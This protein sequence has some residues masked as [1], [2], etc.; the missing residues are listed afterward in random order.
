MVQQGQVFQ[1]TA[2]G[3]DGERLWAFRYRT[4]GRDSR[5]VQHGGFATEQDARDALERELDPVRRERQIT[6]EG[7][8][9]KVGL[10]ELAGLRRSLLVW[11][12]TADT[13]ARRADQRHVLPAATDSTRGRR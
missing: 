7:T 12:A 9:S 2:R 1:L 4:G 11:L 8:P 13:A 6:L 10:P 5:R 3:S